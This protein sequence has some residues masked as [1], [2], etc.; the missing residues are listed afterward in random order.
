MKSKLKKSLSLLLALVMAM[1]CMSLGAFAAETTTIKDADGVNRT[2]YVVCDGFYQDGETYD[3]TENFYI[4]NL[5]GL[6]YFR[7]WVNGTSAAMKSYYD[8]GFLTL[9]LASFATNNGMS[10]K[11]VHLLADINLAGEVWQ[12][13]GPN[14][15]S[16]PDKFASNWKA[17]FYGN[18]YGHNHVISNMDT[19]ESEQGE[20]YSRWPQGFF[21]SIAANGAVIDGLV[22]ENV[23]S[24]SKFTGGYAGA[25][26]GDLGTNPYTIS[27]C[28]VRGSIEISGG[29]A[30]AIYGIGNGNVINCNCVV[31]DDSNTGTVPRTVH[32]TYF[33]GGLIGAERC[34]ATSN[35]KISKNTVENVAISGSQ[36]VGGLVGAMASGAAGTVDI[37]GNTVDTCTVKVE[38][39]EK[40]TVD[41]LIAENTGATGATTALTVRDNTVSP[42]ETATTYV[43]Q[44]G[45][46]K[47][48]TLA[49]AIAAAQSGDTVKLL[50][51]VALDS[52]VEINENLTIDL[53]GKNITAD[54]CRALWVKSGDVTINGSGTVAAGTASSTFGSSS[55]VIRVGDSA[56]NANAA[57]LTIGEGVEVK[58]PYCYGVT[59]FGKNTAGITLT[60][61][62]EVN[63]TG[64][65]A[66]VSGNGSDGL[67]ATTMTIN[68]TVSSAK[69]YAIYHPGKGTLTVNGTVRGKGGIEAKGGTVTVS[70]GATVEATANEWNHA[71]YNNGASTSGYAI[72]AV[73]NPNY[74]GNP[75]VTIKGT[76]IGKVNILADFTATI[77][78]AAV[79][80]D[81]NTIATDT[82]ATDDGF[83]WASNGNGTYSLKPALAKI[84]D[85]KY[86][87]L[88]T[89]VAAAQAGDTIDLLGNVDL[90]STVNID[91]NLTINLGKYNIAAYDARA[92]HVQS[93]SLTLTGNNGTVSTSAG[94]NTKLQSASS[95]IRLGDG[96]YTS[97]TPK[98]K[99]SLTIDSGVTVS[100]PYCYGITV[101]GVNTDG[102]ELTVNGK[103]S[104]TG[105]QAA[106]SGNGTGSLSATTMTIGE[107]A[108]VTAT[109]D[110]AIYHPGKGILTVNGKVEGLGGIEAKGGSIIIN[111]GA[112]V[113]A[114]AS[115][116][117]H[118]PY[119]NGAST[120]GYAIAAVSNP[121][122]AG[123]PTVTINN[124]TIDGKAVIVA[125]FNADNVGV[126]TA[127]SNEIAIPEGYAWTATGDDSYRLALAVAKIGTTGYETLQA[128]FDAAADGKTVTL[129]S[130][131][132]LNDRVSIN[133]SMDAPVDKAV[134]LNMN[135]KNIDG[136]G[137][138][139]LAGGSLTIDGEG[140]ISTTE[141]GL[142]PVEVRYNTQPEMKRTLVI[143]KNVTLD[144][145]VSGYGLNIFGT[146][147]A[148]KN[149]IDV[150]VNGTVKSVIFVLGNL[151]NTAN[152]INITVNGTVDSP[153]TGIALNGYANVTVNANAKVTG[154]TGIEVRGGNLTVGAA[155]ITATSKPATVTSNGSG[156]TTDGAAIAV[157][158]HTT[159]LPITVNVNNVT[160]Y[161]YTDFAI[162]NPEKNGTDAGTIS[163]SLSN[164]KAN[165]TNGGT[166]KLS[167]I[168]KADGQG[169]E[170]RCGVAWS[171][172]TAKDVAVPSGF[173]ISSE[174]DQSGNTVWKLGASAITTSD[175]TPATTL[176]EAIAAAVTTAD[177]AASTGAQATTIN[178]NESITLGDTTASSNITV[179]AQSTVKV[180]SK[181]STES[182]GK[183]YSA[184][185]IAIT[186]G[187]KTTTA[188]VVSDG[189][190]TAAI[191]ASEVEIDKATGLNSSEISADTLVDVSEVLAAATADKN[192]DVSTITGYKIDIDLKQDAMQTT[193]GVPQSYIGSANYGAIITAISNSSIEVFDVY[194]EAT[195]TTTTG[196]ASSTSTFD[197][198][199]MV[200]GATYTFTRNFGA[201]NAG[202][203]VKLTNYKADGRVVELG[204]EP[205]GNDGNVTIEMTHFCI[206]TGQIVEADFTADTINSQTGIVNF[207]SDVYL[208]LQDQFYYT[209]Q[210]H[211]NAKFDTV[212]ETYAGND[213]YIMYQ[214]GSGEAVRVNASEFAKAYDETE[215]KQAIAAGGVYAC[216][217][218]STSASNYFE[219]R[220]S[221][222]PTQMDTPI[223]ITLYKGDGTELVLY[224]L[225]NLVNADEKT[226]S[227]STM[228]TNGNYRGTTNNYLT[229]LAANPNWTNTA[230]ALMAFGAACKAQDWTK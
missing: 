17:H 145:S 132:T 136:T 197:A 220:H 173:V 221:V 81:T 78:G 227:F 195:V 204:T 229:E 95:V 12:P 15:G 77:I 64:D 155:T 146:N 180:E 207:V 206:V 152:E 23:K 6:K 118:T 20:K 137:R 135:G 80:A 27:N 113:K 167:F 153:K 209:V 44:I 24:V 37:T 83:V 130:N 163:V 115:E 96:F 142:A 194:P 141:N 170:E 185:E 106:V 171:T 11:N 148:N 156:T 174:I 166:K 102:M 32:G 47:Y 178:V 7:D 72:A 125:D 58:S 9:S 186:S 150:T 149:M 143:G 147:D 75:Q 4:T 8:N 128:A 67:S 212:S 138:L 30:G 60:V 13:I 158:Q 133:G 172:I 216:K 177:A 43:A 169:A 214:Y 228:N 198:S 162:S 53:N 199:G 123:D 183:T 71:P 175:T 88:A 189:A 82:I 31:G 99:A 109:Q 140:T 86:A 3:K 230:N 164:V 188:Y 33:A 54:S 131:V 134:T 2:V 184:Q 168:A 151:K 45:N 139:T 85:T 93:G 5:S 62:G 104:V 107:N 73:N 21:G 25:I 50:A 205:V 122:Y 35:L 101:F 42:V 114:T 10:G 182:N 92:L 68:G 98:A 218:K 34:S 160:L 111:N 55:S 51:D 129:L 63:V 117:S 193:S 190:T 219:I 91:K 203:S 192:V 1:S 56:T 157:A 116:Q 176:E 225:G 61:N 121:N 181:A 217:A 208:N 112:T 22:L 57:G 46:D 29:Y 76:V 161:G 191:P 38:K 89:A 127:K 200:S 124:A 103:V 26:V 90:T 97:D 226:Y 179:A 70:S 36:F 126:V 159:K 108:E 119:N 100:S 69:D 87:T 52:T 154:T 120:S 74:A 79:T 110:Y 105:V 16:V 187:D 222:Y 210:F 28:E 202:K 40:V 19:S 224:A 84:G 144:G 66:A 201:A 49:D 41:S 223:T 213:W 59:A 65:Q 196:S 39:E 215:M 165:L 18:F 48:E 14:S 94:V 211:V